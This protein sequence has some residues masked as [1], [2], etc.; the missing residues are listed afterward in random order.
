MKKSVS[1]LGIAAYLMM[2]GHTVIGRKS[3][4]IYFEVEEES[5]S[6]FDSCSFEYLSSPFRQFDTSLMS[7]KKIGEYLPNDDKNYRPATDLGVA[8]YLLMHGFK[9]AGRKGRTVFFDVKEED[10]EE[11]NKL[12]FDYLSTTYHDFDSCLMILKKVGEYSP[13]DIVE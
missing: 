1:D 5:L 4:T 9:V 8:A 3:R 2:H 7:L 10:L 6:D 12:N 11:F 13:P